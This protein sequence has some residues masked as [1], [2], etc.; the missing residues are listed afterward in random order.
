MGSSQPSSMA[1]MRRAVVTNAA[2]NAGRSADVRGQAVTRGQ[3]RGNQYSG[4][5]SASI[6]QTAGG[7]S[8]FVGGTCGTNRSIVGSSLK[9]NRTSPTR[10]VSPHRRRRSAVSF[11]GSAELLPLRALLERLE[12]LEE[13]ELHAARSGE[14]S[15]QRAPGRL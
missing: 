6:A 10:T 8:G 15:V 2:S 4:A 11:G 14:A 3:S 9:W 7:W 12:L 1:W 5:C 13:G